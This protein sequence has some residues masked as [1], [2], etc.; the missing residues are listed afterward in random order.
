MPMVSVAARSEDAICSLQWV[1]NDST[2]STPP[3]D[4]P[5]V[6]RS[7]ADV[8]LALADQ[9]V[10][11]SVRA[12]SLEGTLDLFNDS[13]FRHDPDGLPESLPQLTGGASLLLSSNRLTAVTVR[14]DPTS[15]ETTAYDALAVVD[16]TFERP[17]STFVAR[18]LEL[19]GNAFNGS[20]ATSVAVG[21]V[22]ESLV[23]VG[24]RSRNAMSVQ[25]PF[26]RSAEAGNLL[27]SLAPR[28]Q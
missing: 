5:K 25:G 17:G 8:A 18:D 7:E 27:V 22:A 1:D 14:H 19:S 12:S 15:L 13:P 16:N 2:D 3:E 28:P 11:G 6:A 21:V 24:N 26:D 9:H 23:M 20:E 4:G 10:G